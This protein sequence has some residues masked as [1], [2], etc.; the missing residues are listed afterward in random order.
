MGV[1]RYTVT[2]RTTSCP[3]CGYTLNEE[4]HGVLTPVISCLWMFTFPVLIPYA[5]I[6][7][8][9]FGNPDMPKIGPK[10]ITCPHCSLPIRTKN[11]AVEDL[12]PDELVTY[13]FRILFYVSYVLGAILSF[14]LLYLLIDKLP[15]VSI[16][17]LI[18]LFSLL[19]VISIIVAYRI[20]LANCNESKTKEVITPKNHIIKS[21]NIKT[22][23]TS[24]YFYCRKCGNKLPADSLFC[25]KCGTEVIK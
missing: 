1:I 15:I 11:L 3:H 14:T 2:T 22:N 9:G 5:I 19:G 18:A 7:Y 21:Q 13:R 10:L 12:K 24:E 17:G 4:T 25:S 23:E 20:N 16:G 6:K 8:L